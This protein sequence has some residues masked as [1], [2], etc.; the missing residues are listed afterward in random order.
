MFLI[1]C[2]PLSGKNAANGEIILFAND[3]TPA[4][5]AFCGKDITDDS[6]LVNFLTFVFPMGGLK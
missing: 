3:S 5:A 6:G 4:A 1:N 2:F